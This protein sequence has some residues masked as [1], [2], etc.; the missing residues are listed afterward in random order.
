V[1]GVAVR[2]NLPFV[3]GTPEDVEA[4]SFRVRRRTGSVCC[5]SHHL[6]LI[7]ICL[8]HDEVDAEIMWQGVRSCE[9]MRWA[10][11]RASEWLCD[12]YGREQDLDFSRKRFA[13]VLLDGIL[14]TE[15]EM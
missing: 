8:A 15:A 3:H 2:S 5:E 10:D 13:M 6:A 14:G 4:Y 1:V 7:T 12:V 11:L 9:S